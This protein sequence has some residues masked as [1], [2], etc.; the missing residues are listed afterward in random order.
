MP[1]GGQPEQ[2]RNRERKR[3]VKEM[4]RGRRRQRRADRRDLAMT[5]SKQKKKGDKKIEEWSKGRP[6]GWWWWGICMCV[7]IQ[8][9][10]PQ[11]IASAY[12][13]EKKYLTRFSL[14]DRGVAI[15]LSRDR[16]R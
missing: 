5:R 7:Y 16:K 9:L 8:G 14:D 1:Q 13:Q 2:P 3:Y 4:G 15:C 12:C 10:N 11:N 6:R